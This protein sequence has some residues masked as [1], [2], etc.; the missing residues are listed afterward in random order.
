MK[1][2]SELGLL[3]IILVLCNCCVCV[4]YGRG[5]QSIQ[6]RI[7]APAASNLSVAATTSEGTQSIAPVNGIY[8]VRLPWERSGECM[9]L[10]I[11]VS[12]EG[13]PEKSETISITQGNIVVKRITVADIRKLPRSS[14]GA[15]IFSMK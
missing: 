5:Q 13:H 10:C 6:F 7:E 12:G 1:A 15:Y 3:G 11:R 9:V 14:D 2:I 8:T 4:D